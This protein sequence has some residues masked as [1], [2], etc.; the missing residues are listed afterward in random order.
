MAVIKGAPLAIVVVDDATE[1]ALTEFVKSFLSF[2][3]GEMNL[4]HGEGE[5][6]S[7]TIPTT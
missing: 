3:E 4:V 5:M 6:D 7:H 1:K 2:G